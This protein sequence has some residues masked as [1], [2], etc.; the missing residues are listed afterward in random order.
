MR[1]NDSTIELHDLVEGFLFALRA[2]GR[3]ASTIEYYG[4][5]LRPLLSY[6]QQQG[7][8]RDVRSLDARRLREFLMWTG[9]R[10]FESTG[11]NGS[12]LPASGL[13]NRIV[14]NIGGIA[15]DC[16]PHLRLQW[17]PILVKS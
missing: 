4:Y 16:D 2:E 13:H 10:V 15:Y 14:E 9:C 6:G 3:S 11:G 5:L 7:W 17:N 8:L 1:R 12:R